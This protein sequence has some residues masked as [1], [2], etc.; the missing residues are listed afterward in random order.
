MDGQ[1]PTPPTIPPVTDMKPGPGDILQDSGEGEWPFGTQTPHHGLSYCDKLL[2]LLLSRYDREGDWQ[3]N[4][5][6]KVLDRRLI[7]M[8]AIEAK[9]KTPRMTYEDLFGQPTTH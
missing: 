7:C 6:D 4:L 1:G 5:F 9:K 2:G 3:Q 8:R